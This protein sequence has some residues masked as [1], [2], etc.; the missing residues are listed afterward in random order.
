MHHTPAIV[1]S[2]QYNRFSGNH[3]AVG[4]ARRFSGASAQPLNRQ[5]RGASPAAQ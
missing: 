1:N 3:L 5:K 2:D 4:L